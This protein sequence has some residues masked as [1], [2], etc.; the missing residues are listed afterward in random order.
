MSVSES[1]PSPPTT[2]ESSLKRKTKILVV[3]PD[4]IGDV[5]LSTPVFEALK[6]HNL[7]AEVSVLVRDQVVPVVEHNPFVSKVLA[8]SPTTTHKGFSG[9][10]RLVRD[11]RNGRYDVAVVLQVQ[12]VVTL[13]VF[14]AGVRHRL[15]PYSKWYSLLFFN[16]GTRQSRSNVEMHEADYNLML[17]RRL[18]IRVP[19]RKYQP[20]IVV[21]ADAKDRMRAYLRDCGFEDGS[22]FVVLHPGMGGSALN[23][24][25][26][27]YVDLVTLLILRGVN[28]MITGSSAERALVESVVHETETRLGAKTTAALLRKFVGANSHSGLWDFMALQSLSSLVIAPS[29]G[30]LHIATALGKPT[31]SFFSPI[32][33]QSALRWGPYVNDESRHTVLVP[34][35]L[36]GQDFKCAGKKCYFYFCMERLSVEEAVN[37][38]LKQLG[39]L[40]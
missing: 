2:K 32:R 37:N 12:F 31:V 39:N 36:C 1:Q 10:W 25:K 7:D 29:T 26:G 13:A 14:F 11:I 23:W 19:S 5:V 34:D 35:A 18:G 28:V 16:R 9:F 40:K 15:G 3:R 38:V 30:P 8:Y 4:R 24:P 21:D 17:L 33:V 22:R 20:V 6:S 27:Y